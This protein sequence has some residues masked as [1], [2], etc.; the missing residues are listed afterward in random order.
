MRNK[1]FIWITA[2]VVLSLTTARHVLVAEPAGRENSQR[3]KPSGQTEK[4][5]DLALA[6]VEDVNL[7][8][9]RVEG[10]DEHKG[11][12]A[13]VRAASK[14]KKA[15]ADGKGLSLRAA[16]PGRKGG[17]ANALLGELR[18]QDKKNLR[19]SRFFNENILNRID[20]KATRMHAGSGDDGQIVKTI[21]LLVLL[22]PA[23]WGL[24]L[25]S[26]FVLR[27]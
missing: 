26:R 4:M 9:P 16:F 1:R 14:F 12:A 5:V 2:V 6:W 20:V 15:P 3:Q 7:I 25:V 19:R 17:D 23:F 13:I 22:P 11:R 24:V 21:G 27:R 10:R 8:S 18:T